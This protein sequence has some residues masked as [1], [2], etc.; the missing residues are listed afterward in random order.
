MIDKIRADLLC[1]SLYETVNKFCLY[2]LNNSRHDA[3]DVTQ[4]VFLLFQQKA[5]T[6]EDIH[7]KSWLLSTANFK[8]KEHLRKCGKETD[9][10]SIDEYEVADEIVDVC[11]LLEECNSFDIEKIDYYRDVIFNRLSKKEQELYRKHFIERKSHS[12]IA[13]EMNTNA[14]NISVM[15]SRLRKKIELIEFLVLCTFGQWIIKLFF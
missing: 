10:V 4:E 2:R 3:D 9:C 11:A 1:N 15:L 12:Q 14:K 7:I 13:E 6:L 8:C 5:D